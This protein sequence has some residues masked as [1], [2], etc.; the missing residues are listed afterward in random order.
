MEINSRVFVNFTYLI[1][2]DNIIYIS[3]PQIPRDIEEEIIQ[4][5]EERFDYR[6]STLLQRPSSPYRPVAFPTRDMERFRKF[7]SKS[8]G[9]SNDESND[10]DDAM[11]PLNLGRFQFI[12][13]S[14]YNIF[15]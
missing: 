11:L 2:L 7:E 8:N 9:E 1:F 14:P 6:K 4:G 3:I 12:F 15:F 5:N 13:R 10:D